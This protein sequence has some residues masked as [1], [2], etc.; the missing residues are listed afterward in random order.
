VTH[1]EVRSPGIWIVV[2][3]RFAAGPVR[4]TWIWRNTVYQELI[5]T[6]IAGRNHIL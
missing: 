2:D 6:V 1:K 4:R 3:K 5:Q